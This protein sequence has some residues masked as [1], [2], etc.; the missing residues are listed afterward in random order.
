MEMIY[1]DNAATTRV[2]D[3]VAL[4][5][6]EVFLESYGNASSLH[7]VGQE[8]KRHLEG[9]REKIAAYFGC[10]PKE[11]TFTSGGTESNNLAIRGLAKANPEKK[12]I[13][14]SVIEH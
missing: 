3:A 10:E 7:D 4:A 13:V 14:T 8:A 9:S 11:I 1:L 2:D 5:V 12:H 6:N